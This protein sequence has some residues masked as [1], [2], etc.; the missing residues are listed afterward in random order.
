MPDYISVTTPEI[1]GESGY[2]TSPTAYGQK[3][4][5]WSYNRDAIC[6]RSSTEFEIDFY[7]PSSPRY[8]FCFCAG[9]ARNA[10][11]GVWE[12]LGVTG[13]NW[14]TLQRMCSNCGG[15]DLLSGTW[16][17]WCWAC[18]CSACLIAKGYD[19]RFT[20]EQGIFN[21]HFEQKRGCLP[22]EWW[23][24]FFVDEVQGPELG[25]LEDLG[26]GTESEEE[27]D[28]QQGTEDEEEK[29]G[30]GNEKET[31]IDLEQGTENEEATY[32]EQGTANEEEAD[33]DLEQG[34]KN[35]EATNINLEQGTGN[36]EETDLEQGTG[37]EGESDID[38]E[39]G[40]ANEEAANIDLEQGTENEEAT[41]LEHDIENGG[42]TDVELALPVKCDWLAVAAV[43]LGVMAMWLSAVLV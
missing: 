26:Q 14:L 41:D 43:G 18:Q 15:G 9:C 27:T 1:D 39:Q 6:D 21:V 23:H 32:L 7:Y 30:T 40:T 35:E 19:I 10:Y 22:S 13:E 34:T 36:E 42:E 12:H 31:D 16:C 17:E 8:D 5:L 4:M 37:N 3:I 25:I 11:E 33:I 20:G 2:N 38:P 29:Q 24:I 28:V